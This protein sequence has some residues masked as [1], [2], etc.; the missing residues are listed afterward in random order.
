M[1]AHC[2]IN[3]ISSPLSP[4]QGLVQPRLNQRSSAQVLWSSP[5]P[6]PHVVLIF[7]FPG[8]SQL[9]VTAVV[10]PTAE[11]PSPSLLCLSPLVNPLLDT[12]GVFLPPQKCE[13]SSRGSGP[14][15]LA[16]YTAPA[17]LAH[18]CIYFFLTTVCNASFSPRVLLCNCSHFA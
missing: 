4:A 3:I 5:G 11:E 6:A 8:V 18:S 1:S 13:K 2:K 9:S 17:H 7:N 16:A 14:S 10:Y 15:N 12:H